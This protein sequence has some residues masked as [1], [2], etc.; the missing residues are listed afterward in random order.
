[1]K[2]CL[3]VSVEIDAAGDQDVSRIEEKLKGWLRN[4]PGV[5]SVTVTPPGGINA[6]SWRES[7]LAAFGSRLRNPFARTR[8]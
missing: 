1:M 6:I 4:Q 7:R 5:T 8:L 3:N 2:T